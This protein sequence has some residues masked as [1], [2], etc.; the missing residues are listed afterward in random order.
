MRFGLLGSLEVCDDGGELLSIGGSQPRTVLAALLAAEGRAVSAEALIE[1]IWGED[2]PASAAGTLQTYVSRLRRALEPGRSP[3]D[4]AALL[5]SE[6]T[7]Y[8]LAVPGEAVDFRRFEHLADEGRAALDAGRPDDA[9]AALL[10][11]ES[12][13]RGTAFADLADA[14]FARGLAVRLEERRLAAL[15][16]R[17]EAE[18][19]LGRAGP[20]A[21]RAAEAVDA[22]PLRER[23]RELLALALYRSGRQGEALRALDDARRTLADQLGVEPGRPLRELEAAILAH[24]PSLELPAQAVGPGG[25]APAGPTAP[26]AG[27]PPTAGTTTGTTTGAGAGAGA[28]GAAGAAGV[29]TLVGRRSELRQLWAALDEAAEA[30]RLEVVEGEPGIGKTSLLE[31]VEAEAR[32]RG[33]LV[34]WGR[35]HEGGAAPAFWPWLE[36]LRELVEADPTAGEGLEQLLEPSPTKVTGPPGQASY[37]LFEAVAGAL[38]SRCRSGPLVVVIDDLQWA[39]PDSLGLLTFLAGRLREERVLVLCAIRESEVA[40]SDEVVEALAVVSRRP[41]SRRLVLRGLAFGEVSELLR[42]TAGREVTPAVATAI[43]ER[44]EGNP[45]F[46][47]E[48]ARLLAG[49]AGLDDAAAVRRRV[50]VGVRDVVRQRLAR[51][52]GA[53][54]DLLAMAAV[55]GRDVDLDLLARAVDRPVDAVLD[56]LEPAVDA[57]LLVASHATGGGLRF[58]HALV[59]E[60]L[61]D[62]LSSLRRARLHLKAA[63]AVSAATGA[64]EDVAEI[65]AEHLW[66]AVPLGVGSRAAAA[67]ERAGDVAV[68]RGA[69]G[70]AVRLL[71]RAVTLRRAGDE[72]EAELRCLV[73]LLDAQRL[74]GDYAGVATSYE[75]ATRL[76]RRAGRDDLLVELLWA[77]WSVHSIT[78]GF[79]RGRELADQLHAVGQASADPVLRMAGLAANGIQC[80][81]EG[82]ITDMRANLAEAD[83]LLGGI[84]VPA[85]DSLLGYQRL[86]VQT[87][88]A[89][90]LG[91]TGDLDAAEERFAT[92]TGTSP[93]LYQR[94]TVDAFHGTTLMALGRF[95]ALVPVATAGLAADP[96]ELY[97]FWAANLTMHLGLGLV[98]AGEVDLGQ[99]RF[100]EG[101]D[102]YVALGI[103][104]ALPCFLASVGLALLQHGC[105]DDAAARIA[106]SREE[107]DAYGQRW[108]EP[109]VLLAE[110]ELLV[111][112]GG[113]RHVAAARFAEAAGV[114]GAQGSTGVVERVLA[115]ARRHEVVL[116]R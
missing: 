41:T 38:G 30:A 77:E 113:P 87:F 67:L 24:A 98:H 111:A 90:A 58:S 81:D 51:L 86:L 59:R 13:W 78:G 99:R 7:G 93:E 18:L 29:P 92:L 34:V 2:P 3:R 110:A 109:V 43:N 12:L 4:P 70:S 82:R 72:E 97:S 6:P 47:S 104:T 106:S 80:W 50:P 62:G 76:A 108:P 26:G 114:A 42:R 20:V 21:A 74:V 5:L 94:T 83:A 56:D 15:E 36:A 46:A 23:L 53:T 49:D 112:R 107:L 79:A 102:R 88:F 37:R 66:A 10:E 84:P 103:R 69:L 95:D 27:A 25:P 54:V 14:D 105:V 65:V 71:D 61:V 91:L 31:A 32:A 115:A 116:E 55:F 45:F 85:L 75:R 39:D 11:A 19:A 1:A 64:E 44:A 68:R 52:P 22:H 17:L 100:Q 16:H 57:R 96:D 40:R 73:R 89:H 9:V 33:A 101:H 60:S 48:L 28:V 63:D 35:A 8:R